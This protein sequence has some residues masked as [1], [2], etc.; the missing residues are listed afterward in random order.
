MAAQRSESTQ[1]TPFRITYS[2]KKT[3]SLIIPLLKEGMT[4]FILEGK[5]ALR[6]KYSTADTALRLR[7]ATSA[8][9]YQEVMT[10]LNAQPDLVHSQGAA[11]KKTAMH[12]AVAQA[13][14]LMVRLLHFQYQASLDITDAD[15]KSPVDLAM[16]SKS[17]EIISLFESLLFPLKFIINRLEK[18]FDQLKLSTF[19]PTSNLSILSL[20]CGLFCELPALEN[21]LDKGRI[22]TTFGY[23]GIDS[24]E[25][26]LNAGIKYISFNPSKRAL[27]ATDATQIMPLVHTLKKNDLPTTFDFIVLRNPHI[28]ST[29]HL[30]IKLVFEKIVN[31]VIAKFLKPDGLL[32]VSCYYLEEFNRVTEL[33]LK[34]ADASFQACQEKPLYMPTVQWPMADQYSGLFRRSP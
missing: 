26:V 29:E 3:A 10:L 6:K 12:L 34:S 25:N 23:I 14:V 24:S 22:D 16:I 28:I 18:I 33:L 8:G 4:L 31:T 5:H 9:D 19:L 13:N 15:G 30:E 2:P 20:A 1:S 7:Q 27:L 17:Q 21:Y 11:S 32:F